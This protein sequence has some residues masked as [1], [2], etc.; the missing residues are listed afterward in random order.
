MPKIHSGDANRK[1]YESDTIVLISGRNRLPEEL[2]NRVIENIK[3]VFPYDYIICDIPEDEYE[4]Y[5]FRLVQIYKHYDTVQKLPKQ[6]KHIIRVRNDIALDEINQETDEVDSKSALPYNGMRVNLEVCPKISKQQ[7]VVLGVQH[8]GV[9]RVISKWG[10]KKRSEKRQI[11]DFMIF[12]PR[13]KIMDPRE[14]LGRTK[15]KREEMIAEPH[16]AWG[17]VFAVNFRNI[18][19]VQLPLKI[20]RDSGERDWWCGVRI[21]DY[22]KVI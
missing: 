5:Y 17:E 12:H 8:F 16:W 9:R 7:G 6:Y 1:E 3:T 13:D 19:H 20:Y 14:V 22:N 21:P 15:E 4:Q 2:Q 10:S 18:I 11:G